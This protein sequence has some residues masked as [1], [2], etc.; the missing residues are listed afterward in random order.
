MREMLFFKS[1]ITNI[2][3]MQNVEILWAKF[4]VYKFGT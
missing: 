3:S 4:K 1:K 2:A